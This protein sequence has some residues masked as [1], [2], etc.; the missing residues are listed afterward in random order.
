MNVK[1]TTLNS[2][3]IKEFSEKGWTKNSIYGKVGK[4]RNSRH[5]MFQA[6]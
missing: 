5:D 1:V 3:L 4:V 2:L 6:V